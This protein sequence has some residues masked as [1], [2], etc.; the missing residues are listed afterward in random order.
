MSLEARN[1]AFSYSRDQRVLQNVSASVLPG[2]FLAILGVNGCGK[3]TLLSCMNSLLKPA[4]GVVLLDGRD[5]AEVSRTER[6]EKM[7]LVA[8]HS[9]ANRLTV[10][11]AILLGRK[12]RVKGAPSEEDLRIVDEVVDSLGLATYAL[13][14]V[15][16]LSGGEYQ[17]VVLARAFA[18]QTSI[19]LL[20]EPTNNLDPAN[21]QEVMRVVRRAVDEKGLAAVAVLHDVNLALRYCDRFLMIKDGTVAVQGDASSVTE[22]SIEL[23]YGMKVDVIEHKGCKVVVPV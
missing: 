10:Y 12:P 17:K 1:V 23:V 21:Q 18:Q 20:D 22:E 13:R 5:L 3:S 6:A 2:S 15:D 11:D 4:D 19:L 8:Q 14:Y 16:E 9:H 7:A